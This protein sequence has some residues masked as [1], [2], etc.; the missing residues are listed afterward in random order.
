[1]Y[2]CFNFQRASSLSDRKWLT[3][4]FSLVSPATPCNVKSN[5]THTQRSCCLCQLS[6]PFQISINIPFL[7]ITS[8][9]SPP[10]LSHLI[11][12]IP[13]ANSLTE[14]CYTPMAYCI[15]PFQY[16]LLHALNFQQCYIAACLVPTQNVLHSYTAIVGYVITLC[17]SF[18]VNLIISS[19]AWEAEVAICSQG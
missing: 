12:T 18:G 14:S 19:P 10:H 7:Y 13:L 3:F 2:V 15:S 9:P 1:M 6:P 4:Q 11:S 5:L 16:I 17:H 8:P